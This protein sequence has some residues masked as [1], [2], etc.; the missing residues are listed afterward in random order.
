MSHIAVVGGV[1]RELC[2]WPHWDQIYGSAGRAAFA[3]SSLVADVELHCCLSEKELPAFEAMAKSFGVKLNAASRPDSISFDYRHVF[4][5]PRLRPAR[6]EIARSGELRVSADI[7][8]AFG[9]LEAG[10]QIDAKICVYDPQNPVEPLPFHSL[11]SRAARLAIVG[12]RTE[13]RR[14]AKLDDEVAAAKSV[15]ASEGA[16]VVIVKCGLEGALIL[17]ADGI[18]RVPAYVSP[19]GWT[20]GS[21]DVF[22]A[23][24]TVAWGHRNLAAVEA[25]RLAS[26]AVSQYVG[27]MSLPIEL[28][29]PQQLQDAMPVG[30]PPSVYLAGPFFTMEQRWLVEEALHHLQ[31]LGAA[32][33]SP[34]HEIGDGPAEYVAKADIK[35]LEE[36]DVILS[37]I[38]GCDPG[39]IFEVGYGVA[40]GKKVYAYSTQVSP[41]D[42]KMLEGTGVKIIDD[43]GAALLQVASRA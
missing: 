8:L 28:P 33:F 10:T 25:A 39:T 19:G 7:V 22:A 32:V 21:G 15:L 35:A 29:T 34:Y 41:G 4:D 5:H 6:K 2:A 40:K 27:S 36:S 20:L 38:D 37:L 9:M 18:E 12:N 42:L 26:W 17:T 3:I 30:K 24:F 1:Y 13:I 14:L 43:F 11:S 16:E 31:G 23:A